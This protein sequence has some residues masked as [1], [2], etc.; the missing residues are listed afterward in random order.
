MDLAKSR[1]DRFWRILAI[2]AAGGIPWVRARSRIARARALF[3]LF[4][5]MFENRGT[6]WWSEQ[7]LNFQPRFSSARRQQNFPQRDFVTGLVS[8]QPKSLGS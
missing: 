6:G 7:D 4:S 2:R 5:E 8:S 3:D 1:T